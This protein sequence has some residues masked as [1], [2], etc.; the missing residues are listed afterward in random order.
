MQW[1]L[2]KVNVNRIKI[3]ISRERDEEIKALLKKT[4]DDHGLQTPILVMKDLDDSFLL[5]YGEGRW[6]AHKELGLKEIDALVCEKNQL[7]RK[8]V[9]IKWLLE[10]FGRKKESRIDKALRLAELKY[11]FGSLAKAAKT[12]AIPS[13]E[14][15][16]L[17]KYLQRTDPELIRSAKDRKLSFRETDQIRLAFEDKAIQKVVATVLQEMDKGDIQSLINFSKRKPEA[18]TSVGSLRKAIADIDKDNQELRKHI[19]IEERKYSLLSSGMT[20]LLQN[21]PFTKLLKKYKL[22]FNLGGDKK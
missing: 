14:A 7:S 16:Y 6:L 4:I 19:T 18:A 2:E 21:K 20:T 3:F 11:E 13:I 10:N 1:Q 12:L 15:K 17:F 5:I 22:A 9:A 8:E